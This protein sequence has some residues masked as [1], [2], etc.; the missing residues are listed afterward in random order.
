MSENPL[1]AKAARKCYVAIKL[2]RQLK[3]FP[4]WHL[5]TNVIKDLKEKKPEASQRRHRTAH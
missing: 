2:L 1:L 3:V 5:Y 4:N